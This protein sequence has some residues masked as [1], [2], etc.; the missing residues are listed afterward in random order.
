MFLWANLLV[1]LI[2][3]APAVWVFRN[4]S[5]KNLDNPVIRVLVHGGGGKQMIAA[6]EFLK[7]LHDFD[8]EEISSSKPL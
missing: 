6:L 4:L 5:F 3:I 7:A 2:L 8:N 1:S